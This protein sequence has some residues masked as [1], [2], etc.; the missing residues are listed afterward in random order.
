MKIST[1][2]KFGI[3]AALVVAGAIGIK[4]SRKKAEERKIEKETLDVKI[5]EC[6]AN[7]P[8]EQYSEED[9]KNDRYILKVQHAFKYVYTHLLPILASSIGTIVMFDTIRREQLRRMACLN[10]LNLQGGV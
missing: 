3:G 2:V 4:N 7:L 10:E 8:E 1:V 6:L 9:A 5:K